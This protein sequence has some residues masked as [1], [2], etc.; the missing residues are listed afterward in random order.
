MSTPP[1]PP[2]PQTH[3][4]QMSNNTNQGDINTDINTDIKTLIMAKEEE[5]QNL[6]NYRL[7]SLQSLLNQKTTHL[8]T[9]MSQFAKLRED[10]E[11]NVTVV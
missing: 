6:T 11:Y 5:L 7:E 10:F 3:V 9:V 1:I 4:N 2:T 8:S